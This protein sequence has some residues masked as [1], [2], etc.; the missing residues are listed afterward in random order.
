MRRLLRFV[1]IGLTF[2]TFLGSAAPTSAASCQFLLGFKTLHDLIPASVGSCVTDEQHD[3]ING[4]AVQLTA[5]VN[6]AGGLLVWRKADNWTAYTDGY[7]TWLNGPNGLQQR[8]NT[9][10]FP[11]EA[12]YGMVY[13]LTLNDLPSGF[14]ILADRTGAVTNDQLI[15]N[16]DNQAQERADL[17]QWGRISGYEIGF[18]R[19]T[20]P[21]ATNGALIWSGVNLHASVAGAQA[22]WNGSGFGTAPDGWQ[23]IS[24]SAVGDQSVAFT[25]P[26][27][28]KI[29]DQSTNVT[30]YLVNFRVGSVVAYVRTATPVASANV[31]ATIAFAQ[32]VANRIRTHA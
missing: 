1:I 10:R 20:S 7:R 2:A 23:L 19:S 18:Q 15:A 17:Q 28:L 24:A 27:V 30:D 26:N 22:A 32:I 9:D 16:A 12:D 11:W 5:G 4:N 14:V 6:N 8:L 21:F 13:N 25:R 3:P 31:N 29:G